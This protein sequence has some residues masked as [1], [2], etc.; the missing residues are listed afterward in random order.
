MPF[1]IIMTHLYRDWN[2]IMQ[3]TV[4]DILRIFEL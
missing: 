4:D 1:E 2:K 3:A